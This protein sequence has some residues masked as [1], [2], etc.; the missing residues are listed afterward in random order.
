MDKLAVPYSSTA[1]TAVRI[2]PDESYLA[3]YDLGEEGR[4]RNGLLSSFLAS[5]RWDPKKTMGALLIGMVAGIG[6]A[7]FRM[8]DRDLKPEAA[9]QPV[10]V[11]QSQPLEAAIPKPHVAPVP[12]AR[13]LQAMTQ[14]PTATPVAVSKEEMARIKARNRRLEA[15][16]IVLR[17]RKLA[18]EK[19]TSQDSTSLLGQ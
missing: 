17:Q 15:L 11:R 7:S 4:K 1:T 18:P 3:V 5:Y 12:A 10:M 8:S 9:P 6:V 14:T 16:I 19:K 13:L 2:L